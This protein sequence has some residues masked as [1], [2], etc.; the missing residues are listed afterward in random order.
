MLHVA[1]VRWGEAF[2]VEYV[3]R[4]FDMVRRN[5]PDGFAGRFVCF[6]DR[7]A[8]L[9]HLKGIEAAP[10]PPSLTGWWNKMALFRAEAFPAGDRVWYFDLDTCIVGP[11]EAIFEYDG[12]FGLLQDV[13]RPGGYQSS[14]MSWRAGTPLAASIWEEWQIQKCPQP[15]GGD[16]TVLE[17]H[18][19][20]WLPKRIG[21]LPWPPD[22]L[23]STFPGR[24]RSYKVECEREIPKGT[25]VVFFH[26]LPRPHQVLTGWVPDIWRV[27]GGSAIEFAP[28]VGTITQEKLLSN[29]RSAF[30]CGY[31]VLGERGPPVERLAVICGGGPSLKDHALLIAGLA[32][33]GAAIFSVNQVD[34]YLR[35]VG[36]VPHFHVMVDGRAELA[37]WVNPA[38]IKLYA[39]M[40]DPAVLAKA[41]ELGDLTVWHAL[42]QDIDS[43]VSRENLFVGGGSTVGTRALSLAY[44]LGFRHLACFGF[45]SSYSGDAHHVYPQS[46]NDADPILDVIAG[47]KSFRAAGW[48]VKQAEEFKAL[49]AQLQDLGCDLVIYGE[50]LLPHM[51]SMVDPPRHADLRAAQLLA[52]LEGI[53]HPAGAEV[54][55]FA[56]ELSRLLLKREDLKLVMV[57]SWA[58]SSPDGAYAQSGDFHA[59]LN[60]LSQDAFKQCAEQ[61][62]R[63]AGARRTFLPMT[64]LEAAAAIPDASL[65]F[66]FLDADHSYEAVLA[67]IA[68]WLP[69]VKPGGFLSGH[70]YENTE[71]P[72]FGVKRAVDE[73]FGSPELGANFTWRVRMGAALEHRQPKEN[74]L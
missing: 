74:M 54:G 18:W 50:G 5:L 43:V 45:D 12:A 2:G 21:G 31:T 13:Y 11:L 47:G 60:Q 29:V 61:S 59:G 49:T 8:D 10:L 56:G 51:L 55:V 40:C 37:A 69:K 44:I 41:D 14:V 58:T 7:P 48:M 66:V 30:M 9:A 34:H 17:M 16:Q 68:A 28:A 72:A 1:C 6:T 42:V 46:L 19:A 62:T 33:A 20:Q 23:Q 71:Y 22:F 53:D 70:D 32:A 15:S 26:G 64:S 38:G 3:E 52:W 25:S 35:S 67:D 73:R 36:V 65:D 57:D 63:F 24:F 27:G 4:L 39:S